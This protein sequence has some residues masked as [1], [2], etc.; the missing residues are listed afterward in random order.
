M[1]LTLRVA[2]AD[3]VWVPVAD[4]D[5]EMLMLAV[6]LT[7]T[8]KD[9]AGVEEELGV[10]ITLTAAAVIVGATVEPACTRLVLPIDRLSITV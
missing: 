2:E 10:A 8:D 1:A 7:P 4:H 5:R 6:G 9:A 3:G